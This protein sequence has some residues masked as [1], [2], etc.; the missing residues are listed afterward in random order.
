MDLVTGVE[1]SHIISS[2]P[3]VIGYTTKDCP[4]R[5]KLSPIPWHPDFQYYPPGL[6]VVPVT[7]NIAKVTTKANKRQQTELGEMGLLHSYTES[8]YKHLQTPTNFV[9]TNLLQTPTNKLS[10]SLSLEIAQF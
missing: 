4:T 5:K 2:T 9:T 6:F 3:R 1:V 8:N 10:T 7:T